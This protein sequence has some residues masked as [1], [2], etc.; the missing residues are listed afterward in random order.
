MWKPSVTVAAV[1]EHNGRFLFVEEESD[2][3]VVINQPAG[4]LDPNE[5]LPAAVSREVL[6]ETRFR[7]TPKSLVGVYLWPHETKDISYL[8]FAFTGEITGE[9]KERELD[10]GIIRPLWLTPEELEQ[11]VERHRSVMVARCVNDYRAGKRYPLDLLAS[12]FP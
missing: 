11:Q 5:S 6:E 8:R 7:F 2:G 3:L 9:V 1:V 10:V 12:Y 4:H